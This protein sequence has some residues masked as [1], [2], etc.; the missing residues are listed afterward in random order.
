MYRAL[1]YDLDGVLRHWHPEDTQALERRFGLPA[2]AI[3]AAAFE[4][5]LLERALTG[6]IPDETWRLAARN[7]IARAHGEDAAAAIDAWS[8][9]AGRID[10]EMAALIAELRP[11]YRTGLL[12]NATTRLETDL[13]A[14]KLDRAFDV[15][16]SSA[17]VGFAKPDPRIYHVAAVRLGL[18]PAECLYIDDTVGH[19]AAARAFGMTG[20]EF[21]GAGPLRGQ[22]AALGVR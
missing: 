4:P 3:A 13:Q 19:V 17:R 14:H 22:L 10:T 9:G 15:V 11:R 16:V 8:E 20:I 21:R 5:V 1:I 6:R 2:G 7:A 18:L 12:T